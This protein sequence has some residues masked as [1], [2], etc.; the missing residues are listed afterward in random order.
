MADR[1]DVDVDEAALRTYTDPRLRRF[2]NTVAREIRHEAKFTAPVRTGR[3]QQS[4]KASRADLIAPGHY[5]AEVSAN[6]RYARYVHE[7]TR[8]HIIRARRAPALRFYWPRV[9]RVVFFKS[10][11]HPGTKPNPFLTRAA[12]IVAARYR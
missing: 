11:H 4:I 10:V 8:P 5:R 9:G 3:L 2:T 12:D 6:T 7:G 1:V